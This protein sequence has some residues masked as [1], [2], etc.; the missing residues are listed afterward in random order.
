MEEALE[1]IQINY[2]TDA[3]PTL[4]DFHNSNAFL[5]GLMGTY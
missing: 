4:V 2:T 5:R 1:P 3:A